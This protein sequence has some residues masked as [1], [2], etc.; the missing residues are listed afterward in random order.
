[1]HQVVRP[2][3]QVCNANADRKQTYAD[4]D[5]HTGAPKEA[6]YFHTNDERAC[7]HTASVGSLARKL[8]LHR[9]MRVRGGVA[10]KAKYA[11]SNFRV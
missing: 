10:M 8:P 5:M 2:R 7:V 1:M 3:S 9:C 6:M 4:T 11:G